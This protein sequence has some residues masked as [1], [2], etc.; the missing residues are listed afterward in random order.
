[1]HWHH[2]SILIVIILLYGGLVLLNVSIADELLV[3]LLLSLTF[4]S[5]LHLS[6]AHDFFF[7]LTL[8]FGF[9]LLNAL[10]LLLLATTFSLLLLFS[11]RLLLRAFTLF[12]CLLLSL[13]LSF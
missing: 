13:A 9:L 4:L 11:A 6:H 12:F 1:L 8:A 10:L 3:T 7:L 5:S 2:T